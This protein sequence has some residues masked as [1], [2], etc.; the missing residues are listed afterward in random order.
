MLELKTK[1]GGGINGEVEG[2]HLLSIMH[3]LLPHRS[4]DPMSGT[5]STIGAIHEHNR[6]RY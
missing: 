1:A 2:A 6:L 4:E 5:P 3:A